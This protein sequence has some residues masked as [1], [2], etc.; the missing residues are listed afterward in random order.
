MLIP[1]L[2]ILFDVDNTLVDND[3]FRADLERCLRELLGAEAA[4][5]YWR[6]YEGL[7][8]RHGY[9]DYLGSLQDLREQGVDARALAQVAAYALA[10][11]FAQRLY[12]HALETLAHAA[13]LAPVAILS[14]GDVVFQP[15]KIRRAG[16]DEAVAG[17]VML[18][19]HKEREVDELER[20]LPARHYVLVDDKPALLSRMK[21]RLGDRLTA[22]WVRQGH[23][24]RQPGA[25]GLQPAPDLAL[26]SIAQ[27]RQLRR[28]DLAGTASPATFQELP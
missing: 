10:Y 3:A 28:D 7:R 19:V 8:E 27:F 14:D 25:E 1:A 9:V 4:E 5:Q 26:D 2:R 13:T 11:P 21:A 15:R 18:C 22:V 6:C 17:R 20:R 16:I 12:P 24:A 23:Y